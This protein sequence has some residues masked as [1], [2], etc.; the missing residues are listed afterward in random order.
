MATPTPILD[1]C[2]VLGS[3]LLDNE[4]LEECYFV[5]VNLTAEQIT[6]F[7]LNTDTRFAMLMESSDYWRCEFA[8]ASPEL[9][10]EQRAQLRDLQ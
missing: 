5:D 3:G 2:Y 7:R 1:G 4:L 6:A 10:A 8:I 9:S